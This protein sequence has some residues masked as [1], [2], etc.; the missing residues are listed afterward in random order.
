MKHDRIPGFQN[1]IIGSGHESKIT[2][3]TKNNKK[4]KPTKLT[5]RPE[6]LGII[7]YKFACN[8]SGTLVSK[9]VKIKKVNRQQE[10]V[11]VNYLQCLQV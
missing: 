3:V 9:I 10:E 7:G 8:I 4:K 6:P 11:T 2:A 5:S 1:Y